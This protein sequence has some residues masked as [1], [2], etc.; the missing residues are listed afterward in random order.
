MN[1]VD[2]EKAGQD[3][4]P[5]CGRCRAPLEASASIVEVADAA[6]DA[7]VLRSPLPVLLDVWATWCAPCRTMEPVVRDLAQSFAGRLRVA[8]LDV[9]RNP[10]TVARLGIQGV[11]TLVVFRDGREVTRLIGARPREE[12]LG[13]VSE[14]V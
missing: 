14:V 3:L 12:I 2:L 11:P 7:Q 1:R 5:V 13:V 10:A 4:Q 8:K 9:D 6:F